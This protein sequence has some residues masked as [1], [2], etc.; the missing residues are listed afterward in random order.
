MTRGYQIV[1]PELL[2][3]LLSN[4]QQIDASLMVLAWLIGEV[5][6]EL[7]GQLEGV[8]IEIIRVEYMGAYPALG[9][10]YSRAAMAD[11]GKLIEQTTDRILKKKNVAEFAAFCAG[12]DTDWA[13]MRKR[14][15]A[16]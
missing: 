12:T 6:R 3:P 5:H 11:L 7:N 2:A 10:W 9:V 1:E 16:T 15:M 8:E 4:P 14:V 13:A